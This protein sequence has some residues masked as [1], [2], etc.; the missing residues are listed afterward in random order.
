MNEFIRIYAITSVIC[1]ILI[2]LTLA[3]V[4]ANKPTAPKQNDYILNRCD[5]FF[6]DNTGKWTECVHESIKK[7]EEEYG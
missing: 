2:L 7:Y 3:L 1:S 5:Q 6:T 4:S